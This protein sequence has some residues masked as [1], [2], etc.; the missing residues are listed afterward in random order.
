MQAESIKAIKP[1]GFQW[2][3]NNPFL[4][5]VHHKDSYP[6]GNEDL[7]PD[8]SLAGRSI[9]HDFV[10]K[11]GWRMYHGDKI[12]GFP[13][14][15]HRGFETI[16][17]VLEGMVDHADSMGAA[18]RYGG[19]DVQW[20][21]AGAG[22]QH[23]EMFPL[24]NMDKENPL[25]LFQIWLNLPSKDKFVD[26]YYTMF[27][28]ED[29]PLINHTDKDGLKTG[30]KLIAGQLDGNKALA[31][32][33][34]SWA[35]KKDTDV[36][37]MLIRMDPLASWSLPV[38]SGD[39]SRSLYFY[40]GNELMINESKVPAYQAVHLAEGT[41]T[42][43]KNGNEEAYLLLLQGKAIQETIIQYGPFVMNSRDEIQE[44]FDDY[45]RTEFGGWPWPRPDQVH[46]RK[47]GRFARYA[48]GREE[49]RR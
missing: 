44:A 22:I 12:P 47:P 15:P 5:C 28:N 21:T 48:D 24:L 14:H 37:I 7:G 3:T 34:D 45:R 20:M 25:E 9:G 35:S 27:W 23:T 49:I 11:D 29:I 36:A 19:G 30:I 16:T 6:R 17:I 32:P 41:N 38:C 8:A 43:I 13:V 33:P 42:E 46:N 31:P 2:E 39:I 26:P 40:R 18:G 4:F 10:P 1:L